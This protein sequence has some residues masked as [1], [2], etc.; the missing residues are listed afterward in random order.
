MRDL[1]DSNRV[2]EERPKWRPRALAK[3]EWPPTY[4][5]VWQWRV[6]QLRILST[7][8]KS[9]AS[10][11]K[12][13]ST[14]P[15]EFIMDWFDTYDP[16]R[17]KNKWIPFVF[18]EKQEELIGFLQSLDADQE[19]GLIEKCRDMGA[20]WVCVA[21]TI[22]CFL[23]I[24]DDATGW[25]SRKR[26]LVDKLGDPDSIFEKLRLIL[27]RMP[28]VFLPKGFNWSRDATFLK[29]TNP[30]NK[31]V[32]AGEAGDS[33]G[34][35]GRK[36]RYFK[37]ESAH[38]ERPEKIESALGDNTNVQ[39]DISSVNGLG[40]VFHRRAQNAQMYT[41]DAVIPKGVVRLMIMSWQ[42]HPLKTQEWYDVRKAKAEREGLQH[43]FA[44]EV[45]RD[46]AAAVSNTVIPYE[47]IRSAVDAH[48]HIPIIAER[49][50]TERGRWVAG[51]D[52]AD[53]G[54]DTNGLAMREWIIW[55]AVEEWGERDP[56]VSA[57]RAI[58]ACKPYSG[59]V[60]VQYDSIG[61]GSGVK[62][63]YN[64]LTQDPDPETGV[65]LL[66][67]KDI[68]FY[69]W[70]A[71]GPVN[72]PLDRI[73]PDDDESLFNKDFFGNVK[74]QAWWS[75]RTRFYKTHKVLTENVYY[76]P[77]QLISLDSDMPLLEKLIKE[78]AQPTTTQSAQLKMIIDKKPP[79]TKSPNLADA[80]VQAFFPLH[81]DNNAQVGSYGY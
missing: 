7:C 61:V 17:S 30:E 9:L 77:D 33:I 8:P 6:E 38:Y 39:I 80:G 10:A 62:T 20:T 2:I 64:R 51:L 49:L 31:A 3:H 76:P 27:R 5:Q 68:P 69:P 22:W 47:W 34:R 50:E 75:I 71:G 73:I 15:A 13:Y 41:P 55:R 53:T 23:F 11:K 25:G 43:I 46:Y 32:I 16:R 78:L 72:R 29:L 1:F 65:P 74:A 81:D 37:D 54:E 60:E 4:D 42:D 56:G 63:E 26:D 21:Y 67:A 35:G 57:R 12:Y 66:R 44:Q 45:D 40:N 58:M 79:G 59:R 28:P 52:V 36:T 19:S 48:I 70:N 14:R 18:F 24:K